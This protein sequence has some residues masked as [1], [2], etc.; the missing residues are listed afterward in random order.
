M[1]N[2]QAL[3]LGVV[4]GLTEYLP[5]SSS[6]HLVLVPRLMGW[7]FSLAEA[8]VFDV[9]VQ[10]GTLV[11]VVVYFFP[12]IKEVLLSAWA[13]LVAKKP[14]DSESSRLGWLVVLATIP[15]VVIGL[16]FKNDIAATFSSP[17]AA[18]GFLMLTGF[19]LVVA[20]WLVGPRCQKPS[21]TSAL[22]IGLAQCLALLPG[23]SRSGSTIAA[24]MACGINR[25]Q[26]ARFSFLM[27]IPVMLGA[28]TIAS[29]D[30]AHDSVLL[31]RMWMPLTI[32]FLGALV[33]GYLVISW[34]M[35]YISRH[36]LLSF[37]GYCLVVGLLGLYYL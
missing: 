22:V 3:I 15:A 10:L 25:E 11:G 29:F 13:D 35:S 33:T 27:S 20:E 32:G 6:A 31:E 16:L 19:L 18:S 2:M 17:V 7:R 1:T 37:A 9:L 26:A 23:V 28:A 5:V 34:F 24:A 12:L 36:R 4:Q 21:V 8:F 14:F 30:L